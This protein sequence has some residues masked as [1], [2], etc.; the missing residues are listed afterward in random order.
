MASSSVADTNC[1]YRPPYISELG[2]SDNQKDKKHSYCFLHLQVYNESWKILLLDDLLLT[3]TKTSETNT[4][5]VNYHILSVVVCT[6][7]Q[8]N[9]QL[10]YALA[11]FYELLCLTVALV[12]K[13]YCSYML[14]LYGEVCRINFPNLQA[15][16][17][18]T[19]K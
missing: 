14:A 18:K 13:C 17:Y 8:P 6:Y 15:P 12:H 10:C 3:P 9:N 2:I 1:I 11:I 19:P 7:Y 16:K 5:K 4:Q